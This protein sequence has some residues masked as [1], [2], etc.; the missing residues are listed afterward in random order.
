MSKNIFLAAASFLAASFVYGV[1][2][3]DRYPVGASETPSTQVMSQSS[4]TPSAATQEGGN[5][6]ELYYQIQLLQQ[7]ILQLRGMVEKQAHQLKK[8]KQQNLD[9]Y[10]DLDRRLSKVGQPGSHPARSSSSVTSNTVA[11]S[12]SSSKTTEL[13]SYRT[14]IDLVLKKQQ[15]DQ[16]A[17]AL[18][19]HLTQYPNGR[20]AG[21]AQYWLGEIYL[22]KK[23]L[24]TSKQWFSLLLSD[25]PTH[26]KVPDSQFK[27]GKVYDLL[28]DKAKAKE[29]L[30]KAAGSNSGAAALARDYLNVNFSSY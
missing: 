22:L 5:V 4:G 24:E 21:N 12:P 7:E 26:N 23:E 25:Y 20:H 16:A 1:E 18:K 8:L 2:V 27:L 15:Y 6:A 14:A 29:Y 3:V 19:T 11:T 28:G 9:D 13:Q 17:E 10:L 30:E